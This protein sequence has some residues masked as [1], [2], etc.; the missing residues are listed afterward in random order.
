MVDMGCGFP[1]GIFGDMRGY[2]FFNNARCILIQIK[3]EVAH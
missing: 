2:Y 3:I 1:R